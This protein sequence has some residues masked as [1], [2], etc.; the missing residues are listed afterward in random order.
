MGSWNTMAMRVARSSRRRRALAVT[1]SSP[2]TRAEPPETSRMPSGSN[3]MTA[4][5]VTDLPDPDSPTTQTV[6]PACTS[7]L[8]LRTTRLP[9]PQTLTD[10]LRIAS[11]AA[12][13]SPAGG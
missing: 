4:S 1:M 11:T 7:R 13:V 3:P 12:L 10:R 8:K 6:S 9:A 2:S 5:D